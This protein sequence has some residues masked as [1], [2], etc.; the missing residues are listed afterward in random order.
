MCDFNFVTNHER[1]ML[2]SAYDTITRLNAWETLGN[3]KEKSFQFTHDE[4]MNKLMNDINDAYDCG[5][6]GFSMGW[7]MQAMRCIQ[8]D[9]YAA[10][11]NAYLSSE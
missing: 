5:H 7:T 6:S 2:K 1:K 8:R 10:Y 11:K 4:T 3:F 9:G